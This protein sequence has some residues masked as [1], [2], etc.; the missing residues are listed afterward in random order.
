MT[1][2]KKKQERFDSFEKF[3]KNASNLFID[4][5]QRVLTLFNLFLRFNGRRVAANCLISSL[6]SSQIR[7]EDS[8]RLFPYG[9]LIKIQKRWQRLL[10]VLKA[11]WSERR[12]IIENY[13]RFKSAG[14]P[15]ETD[16]AS[17]SSARH[18]FGR[19][20]LFRNLLFH[21]NGEW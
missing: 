14:K 17:V 15:F 9:R 12:E 11:H 7:P 18:S 20:K 13:S 3:T 16:S 5:C 4:K 6:A 8:E 19:E 10:R 21:L 2:E 1:I